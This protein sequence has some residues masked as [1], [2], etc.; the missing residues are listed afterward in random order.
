MEYPNNTYMEYG[1]H[2]TYMEYGVCT[3]MYMEY[4]NNDIYFLNLVTDVYS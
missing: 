2:N 4:P 3:Y 1:L